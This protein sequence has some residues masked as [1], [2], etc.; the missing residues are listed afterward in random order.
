MLKKLYIDFCKKNKRYFFFFL[1]TLL[2]VPINKIF[3]PKYYSKLLTTLQKKKFKD[4]PKIFIYLLGGWLMIE[5]LNTLSSYIMSILIPKF[6]IYVRNHLFNHIYNTHKTNYEEL[7]LGEIIHKFIKTPYVLEDVF[8]LIKDFVIKNIFIII[9]ITGYLFY[10]NYKLGC[11]FFACMTVII[12][13]T[14]RYFKSCSKYYKKIDDMH[15]ETYEEI[16]DTLSNLLTIYS[17]KKGD[18]EKKRLS[19]IDKKLFKNQQQLNYCKNKYR[20]VYTIIFLIIIIILN[21]YS[22]HIFIKK[23]I[24]LETFIAII[25]M[26][27]SL[28]DI[29]ISLFHETTDFMY[30]TSNINIIMDYLKKEPQKKE[31]FKDVKIPNIN[32]GL[33]IEIKDLHYKYKNNNKFSLK[34]INLNIKPFE[35]LL[36]MGE[37]GSGKS[38]LCKLI[39]R[40]ISGHQGTIK[41]NGILNTNIIIDD[42]REHII[43]ITQ[44]PNLFNR[45]LKENLMY[46]INNKKYNVHNLLDKLT[47]VG[48]ED[49]RKDFENKMNKKVGKLGKQLSGGQRQIIWILRSLFTNANLIILDEPT[50]SMD[51]KTKK[52]I[53]NLVKE[54]SKKKG[55]IIITHDKNILKENIHNRLILFKN[56]KIDKI[57][58]NL[59]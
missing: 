10:Y 21:Y 19:K 25:I 13:L 49:V 12:L 55:L 53:M 57:I 29:F 34:D 6:K 27:Y 14:F 35:T 3:L 15:N 46:G 59:K 50:S 43:Y 1:L 4:A 54:L 11:I 5:L 28:L 51:I 22:Y 56:K 48:L 23:E 32:K 38:T 8:Y 40:F 52:K 26:N 33:H 36:I 17:S 24:N 7:K 39:I 31:K 2:Y 37:I 9:S 45:T 42:L 47:D 58:K 20:V 16:E 30:T 18:Y 44:H 41:I